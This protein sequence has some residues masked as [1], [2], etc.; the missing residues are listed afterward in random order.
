M[1]FY[2]IPFDPQYFIQGD[3][4]EV[5]DNDK[6]EY[7]KVYFTMEGVGAASR[8]DKQENGTFKHIW[9]RAKTR[10]SKSS[11]WHEKTKLDIVRPGRYNYHSCEV[12]VLFTLILYTIIIGL[13][14]YE[15]PVLLTGPVVLRQK[16]LCFIRQLKKSLNQ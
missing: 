13:L 2:R 10:E 5:D 15:W 8:M 7:Y 3:Y 6:S 14:I 1:H 16:M 12:C 9:T 11:S 4:F